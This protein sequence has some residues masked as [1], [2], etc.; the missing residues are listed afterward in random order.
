MPRVLG[1]DIPGRK[2]VEYALRYIHGIGPARG[3]EVVAKAGIDPMKKADDLTDDE[4]TRLAEILQAGYRIEGDLRREV[5]QNIRRLMGIGCYRGIRHRKGLPV[6]GQRT[7][8]NARTRKGPR[9]TVGAVRGKE[10][11]S[12]V[13]TDVKGAE[14]KAAEPKAAEPKGAEPKAAAPKGKGGQ[15]AG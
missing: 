13:K 4:I 12:A 15:A 10:A 5:S 9:K 6:R 14:V 2:R 8:T 3:R 1:I 11:R 7:S